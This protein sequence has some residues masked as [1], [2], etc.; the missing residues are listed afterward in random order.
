MRKKITS[1]CTLLG[2]AALCGCSADSGGGITEQSA[3]FSAQTSAA[4]EAVVA[5]EA[6][7]TEETSETREAVNPVLLA[8][9]FS[10]EYL[11]L[12][13]S[14]TVYIFR[15][16]G[17]TEE[18]NGV[19]CYGVSCYDD[20]G[21]QLRFICDFFISAD[22]LTAYRYYAE[23]IEYR[24][25]PERP[26]FSGFDPEMQPPEDIFAQANELYSAVYGELP[27]DQNEAEALK[28][29][30]GI[31]YPVTDERLNTIQ[32]LNSAL[33]RYF[34]GDLL[35]RLK[36]GSDSVIADAGGRLCCLP[37]SGGNVGYLGT[38]YTLETLTE[39]RAVYSAV[40]RYEYE[41]GVVS[42]KKFSCTAKKTESGWR[43]TEF[44]LP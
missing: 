23:N 34:A 4:E 36:A 38:D 24:L 9:Q 44:E 29:D 27:Y 16:K 35:E 40:S 28:S 11:G 25:L 32:K 17:E 5:V 7:F 12:P 3:I 30:Q 26:D 33:A 31:Y 19:V 6:D 20:S 2:I 1:V 43:F 21:G 15:D 22:G 18:I 41:A 8:E 10:S 14:D 42:E 37:H 13:D 39:D